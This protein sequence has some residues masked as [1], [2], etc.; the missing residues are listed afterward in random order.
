MRRPPPEDA[1]YVVGGEKEDLTRDFRDDAWGMPKAVVIDNAFNWGGDRKLGRPLAES[2]IY[3]VH[4]KGFTK[5]CPSVPPELRGT[6]FGVF[7]VASGIALLVASA[8]AGYLWQSIGPSATFVAGAAFAAI[9][10]AGL[11]TKVRDI[12]KLGGR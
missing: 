6:A 5:L 2:I 11:A 4:V 10:G 1:G 7:A 9:A 3:E 12:P 8:L